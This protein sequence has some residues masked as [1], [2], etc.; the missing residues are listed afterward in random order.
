MTKLWNDREEIIS[1]NWVQ[2]QQTTLHTY[3]A[4]NINIKFVE[5]KNSIQL[6]IYNSKL[7]K[8]KHYYEKDKIR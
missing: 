8:K 4:L 2:I 6:I 3:T 7:P 5:T 1:K